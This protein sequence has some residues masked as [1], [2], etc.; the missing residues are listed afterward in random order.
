MSEIECRAD[1]DAERL[2]GLLRTQADIRSDT[3]DVCLW[4]KADV[5][6][7]RRQR[8]LLTPS[9]HSRRSPQSI[10]DTFDVLACGVCGAREGGRAL[11]LS[12]IAD[13][14]GPVPRVSAETSPLAL[15]QLVE[16]AELA[17]PWMAHGRNWG[18]NE[19]ARG[20]HD[21]FEAL[22]RALIPRKRSAISRRFAFA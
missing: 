5:Q 2:R 19:L 11:H 17:P 6:R 8:P 15:A 22:A 9:G 20:A 13:T 10:N 7:T 12:A 21:H 4:P 16:E 3:L 1:V 18:L 14:T